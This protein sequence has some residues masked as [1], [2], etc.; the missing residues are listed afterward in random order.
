MPSPLTFDRVN[1]EYKIKIAAYYKGI[2]LYY[3]VMY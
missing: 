2:D 1:R 3:H